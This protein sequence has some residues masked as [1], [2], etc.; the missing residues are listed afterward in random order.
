METMS[1]RPSARYLASLTKSLV[2]FSWNLVQD[3]FKKSA[4]DSHSSLTSVNKFTLLMLGIDKFVYKYEYSEYWRTL[5]LMCKRFW[6]KQCIT[7]F[8]RHSLLCTAALHYLK[9]NPMSTYHT[10]IY[11][12]NT[13]QFKFK[14]AI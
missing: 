5:N 7:V 2:R 4:R 8:F 1:H 10:T 14:F 12:T 9:K 6:T 13:S 3:K 11:F